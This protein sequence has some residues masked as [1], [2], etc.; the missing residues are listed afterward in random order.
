M[1]KEW[2]FPLRYNFHCE[3]EMEKIRAPKVPFNFQF[4]IEMEK[5]IF[6]HFN[7]YFKIELKNDKIFSIFIF[8][9]ILEN[10][11][12]KIHFSCFSFWI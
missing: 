6:A 9:F 5:D 2:P 1:R 11:K 12:L 10:W 8:Q 3:I 4:K 7:F